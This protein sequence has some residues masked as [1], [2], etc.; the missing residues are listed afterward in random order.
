MIIDDVFLILAPNIDCARSLEQPQWDG[1]NEYPQPMFLN[2][3]KKNNYLVKPSFSL[4]K[5]GIPR[6]FITLTC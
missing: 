6:V 3:N 4:Y 1:S 5:E 2:Q